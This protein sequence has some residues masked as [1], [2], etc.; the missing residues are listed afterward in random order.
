[1]IFSESNTQG[2][3]LK[4]NRIYLYDNIKL[5]AILLVVIGHA[6]NFLT[7]DKGNGLEKSLYLTI[8]SIHMPLFIFISGLFF[9]PMDKSAKFPKQKVV[10]YILIGIVL[11]IVMSVL[12]LLL[13]EKPVY[14]L[15]DVY[16]TFTWFM[17]AM[18]VFISLMWLFREYNTKIILL[19]ALLV[20]CM[21]GYDKNLGDWFALMRIVVFFPF[22]ILGY[23][24]N[25]EQLA[26]WLSDKR[27][28][29]ASI[30]VVVGIIAFFFFF[31]KAYPYLRPM[32]TGRNTFRVLG[33]YYSFGGIVR[34][35]CYGISTVFGFS[36]M[37]LL[38]NKKLG[39]LTNVGA[40]T[41]QIYFWHKV[42]LVVMEHFKLYEFIQGIIGSTMA[43]AIYILL[44]V[45]IAFICSLKIF[46]FPT[47]QLLKLGK[48]DSKIG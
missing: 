23:M 15:L 21:A 41:L 27:L 6:I 14:S 36:V 24:I 34:L 32:F 22:F 31:T 3:T 29:I 16:D 37:C 10:S 25:P 42:F 12:R 9:K 39:A 26:K 18:A 17:W 44:A 47:K 38:P 48:P 33:K 8:Y 45:A 5:L 11:R 40:K 35:L 28:K 1:M 4:D 30:F 20:G 43:T 2:K 13:N 19:L 7:D 46:S